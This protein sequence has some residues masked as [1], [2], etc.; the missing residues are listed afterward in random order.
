MA[1]E[2]ENGRCVFLVKK[3][4]KGMVNQNNVV[5]PK[6]GGGESSDVR[7]LGKKVKKTCQT[8]AKAQIWS[9]SRKGGTISHRAGEP[10]RRHP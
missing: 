7:V 1:E 8:P 10:V 4:G 9:P 5:S 2:G 3:G 6:R